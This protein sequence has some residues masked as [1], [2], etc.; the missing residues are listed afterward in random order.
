MPRNSPA[1]GG[2][3]ARPV[4]R[5]HSV[6]AACSRRRGSGSRRC[7]RCTTVRTAQ[8]LPHRETC[9]VTL[10]GDA[11]HTLIAVGNGVAVA[12]RDAAELCRRLGAPGEG[13][14][15]YEKQMLGWFPGR[16]RVSGLWQ[17]RCARAGEVRGGRS[18]SRCGRVA[19]NDSG[20]K[21][22]P[23]GRRTDP[24]TIQLLARTACPR[25]PYCCDQRRYRIRR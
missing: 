7:R 1:H 24:R 12:L 6:R 9:P 18:S 10:P 25:A 15:A 13:V 4:C 21:S 16:G 14:R 22:G 8:P 20:P 3:E 11:I 5:A 23:C 19:D 2:F 17:S